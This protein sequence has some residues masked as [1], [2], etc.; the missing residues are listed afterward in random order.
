MK[1]GRS[2]SMYTFVNRRRGVIIGGVISVVLLLL[3]ILQISWLT[4]IIFTFLCGTFVAIVFITHS[5]SQATEDASF[6]NKTSQFQMKNFKRSESRRV[7]GLDE[8]HENIDPLSSRTF[9]SKEQSNSF[10]RSPIKIN[11]RPRFQSPAG[12]LLNS[13]LSAFQTP[14]NSPI[15]PVS[16]SAKRYNFSSADQSTVLP[17]ADVSVSSPRHFVAANRRYPTHQPQYSSLGFLPAVKWMG[18]STFK[19]T[20]SPLSPHS[21]NKITSP[22]TVKLASVR[23]PSPLLQ[24]LRERHIKEGKAD[25]LNKETVLSALRESKKRTSREQD[26]D[27]SSCASSIEKDAKRRRYE[28]SASSTSTWA[29]ASPAASGRNSPMPNGGFMISGVKRPPAQD[30]SEPS[31]GNNKKKIRNAIAS[32]YSSMKKVKR[33]SPDKGAGRVKRKVADDEES[34]A[35]SS[36]TPRMKLINVMKSPLETASSEKDRESSSAKD[37]DSS[38]DGPAEKSPESVAE[39]RTKVNTPKK[40]TPRLLK[41]TKSTLRKNVPAFSSLTDRHMPIPPSPLRYTQDDVAEDRRRAAQR[42]QQMMQAV[43]KTKQNDQEEEK[44]QDVKPALPS[45]TAAVASKAS[46]L[47]A[48]GFGLQTSTTKSMTT[49]ATSAAVST[50]LPQLGV[51][52]AKPSDTTTAAA[53]TVTITT[54]SSD[55]GKQGINENNPLLSKADRS[56]LSSSLLAP[57]TQEKNSS[58]PCVL[59]QKTLPDST[60]STVVDGTKTSSVTSALFSFGSTP[61]STAANIVTTSTNQKP[62]TLGNAAVSTAAAGLATTLSSAATGSVS[63]STSLPAL[64]VATATTLQ[65]TA[66][67]AVP[68][69]TT[70][71]A[72]AS[73][74]SS[75]ILGGPVGGFNLQTAPTTLAATS[76]T[77]TSASTASRSL[78]TPTTS[79]STAAQSATTSS[80]TSGLAGTVGVGFFS[81]KPPGSAGF[82]VQ[83]PASTTTVTTS[84]APTSSAPAAGFGFTLA[85]KTENTTAPTPSLFQSPFSNLS[86]T[87]PA[88]TTLT[89]ATTV[90]AA[91][92]AATA[93][94]TFTPVF[95][96]PPTTTSL[97]TA[98]S[99]QPQIPVFSVGTKPV[100]TTA[101]GGFNFSLPSQPT[102]NSSAAPIATTTSAPSGVNFMLGKTAASSSST[103]ALFPSASSATTA[104]TTAPM[105]NFTPSPFTSSAATMT[106]SSSLT[107][108]STLTQSGFSAPSVATGSL[109]ASGVTSAA[110]ATTSTFTFGQVGGPSAFGTVASTAQS[111]SVF[112]TTSTTQSAFGTSGFGT[113]TTQSAFGTG[114]PSA[115]SGP[116]ATAAPF[117]SGTQ[118]AASTSS[119]FGSTSTGFVTQQQQQQQTGSMFGDRSQQT[120]GFAFGAQQPTSTAFGSQQPA[121]TSFGSSQA[122]GL[123]AQQQTGFGFGTQQTTGFGTQQ[124]TNPGFGTAQPTGTGFG[125]QQSAF[126]SAGSSTTTDSKPFAFGAPTATAAAASSGSSGFNF[127]AAGGTS[128]PAFGQSTSATPTVAPFNFTGGASTPVANPFTPG[129]TTPGTPAIGGFSVGSTSAQSRTQRLKKIRAKMQKPR[130]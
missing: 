14:G 41:N 91:A 21:R 68:T 82:S 4:L 5:K 34:D 43:E 129:A 64:G 11:R 104:T 52:L 57:A 46:Q 44:S 35:S 113:A 94:P 75:A 102:Q 69:A 98:A 7:A 126:N 79:L 16:I 47:P 90:T 12:P 81:E 103:S 30:G 66:S 37:D 40:E 10:T 38:N 1:H 55:A 114:G 67:T 128:S 130:R 70:S 48:V 42:V 124:Q 122:T 105:F 2:V 107:G 71:T 85:G 112:G 32:S 25:P 77:T 60:S 97:T 33:K 120:S 54:T 106:S 84:T 127:S 3:Y 116:T 89:S 17:N 100:S 9:P 53:T 99:T 6:E 13:S 58:L 18:G 51:G 31:F 78:F 119:V 28:S 20:L 59:Q 86:Q 117:G 19:E 45:Y 15:S 83:T 73:F 101:P 111:Q 74:L 87:T 27:A 76:S 39:E 8:S 49:P 65:V 93:A 95:G 50:S 125:A 61:A 63:N 92:A 110:P 88:S 80:L 22:V 121:S 109:F 36:R 115:F 123:G 72:V 96:P 56:K 29:T 108:T 23:S 118:T 26:D 62:L 24:N